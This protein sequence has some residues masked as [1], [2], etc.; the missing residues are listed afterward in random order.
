M[1]PAGHRSESSSRRGRMKMRA[2]PACRGA[3]KASRIIRAAIGR[4]RSLSAAM[5]RDKQIESWIRQPGPHRDGDA[6]GVVVR[7]G[8][9]HGQCLRVGGIH[10][11]A[12]V[13]ARVSMTTAV[14]VTGI[15]AGHLG[16]VASHDEDSKPSKPPCLKACDED[17]R[18]LSSKVPAGSDQTPDGAR[19][20]HLRY[21]RSTRRGRCSS[22]CTAF[23]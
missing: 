15:T 6:A 10:G 8:L 23:R 22:R 7:A 21:L 13:D 17:S 20:A 12:P 19:L 5:N 3:L 16:V 9:W 1:A 11:H 4:V 14:Q 18:S 2:R